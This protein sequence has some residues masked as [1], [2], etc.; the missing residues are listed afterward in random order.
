MTLREEI[1]QEI[2]WYRATLDT[3]KCLNNIMERIEKLIDEKMKHYQNKKSHTF[4]D[5]LV[6]GENIKL[7]EELKEELTS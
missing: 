5:K 4:M 2:E 1:Q 6:E 3:S 7:L